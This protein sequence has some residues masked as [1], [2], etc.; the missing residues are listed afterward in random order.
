MALDPIPALPDQ[1]RRTRYTISPA[2]ADPVQVGFDIYGSGADPT[3]WIE[4]YVDGEPFTNWTLSSPSGPLNIIARPIT[5]AIITPG[6]AWSGTID[7]VAAERPFRTT[8][9]QDGRPVDPRTFN[10]AI[11][12]L[13][14]RQREAHDRFERTVKMPFGEDGYVFPFSANRNNT[15]FGFDANGDPALLTAAQDITQA[16]RFDIAQSLTDEQKQQARENIGAHNRANI[17]DWG[18]SPG[19]GAAAN[20]AAVQAAVDYAIENGVAIYVPGGVYLLN[21]KI[22]A[23]APITIYGDGF[24]ISELRWTADATDSGIEVV[25]GTSAKCSEVY[26]LSLTTLKVAEGTALT[27][28]YSGNIDG[29]NIVPR[30]YNRA[31][32]ARC[33][34]GGA[35]HYVTDGWLNGIDFISCLSCTVESCRINGIYQGTYGTSPLAENGISF[36]GSGQPTSLVVSATWISA[37][38]K[39]LYT[40]DA[41]GVYV[42]NC[43]FV[44]V[45]KGCVVNNA[46]GE[47]LFN[48]NNSHVASFVTGIEVT[49]CIAVNINGS[50]IYGIAADGGIGVHVKSG[51]IGGIIANNNFNCTDTNVNSYTGIKAE[52][53]GS[54]AG[55]LQI[56]DNTFGFRATS[57]ALDWVGI[58]IGAASSNVDVGRNDFR[59]VGTRILDETTT[60]TYEEFYNY[61]GDLNNITASNRRALQTHVLNTGATNT[62][63][64]I[65]SVAG[66]VVQTLSLNSN[67]AVQLLW[68]ATQSRIYL[69]TRTSG[70]WGSWVFIGLTSDGLPSNAALKAIAEL[71]PAAD[72]LPYFTDGTTAALADFTAFARTLVATSTARAA[73]AALGVP[74]V[75]AQ[76][77]V[78]VSHTGDT[79]ETILATITVPANA[80]GPNG[81]VIVTYIGS[82]TNN[83][84]N[85][86]FRIR[87]GGI[88]GTV[89]DQV[90]L[91]TS[92]S[93]RVQ[94]EIINRNSAM[95]QVGMVATIGGFGSSGTAI[96]TG[97]VDTTDAVDIVITG[98]LA[99]GTDTIALEAYRVEVV[100][101][102]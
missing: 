35:T 65:S 50:D 63:S 17:A 77:G 68:D 86:I 14:A 15:V 54:P 102:A 12:Q 28:D 13:T 52:T 93:V 51:A 100:Y 24:N 16:V 3:A 2:S 29:G 83:G 4:V 75:L 74:F 46:S 81:R 88:G 1:E 10:F 7:I 58:H 6:K 64:G 80:M 40:E 91:T 34:I 98:Q 61:T 38:K 25:A 84:N 39:G 70:S 73:A 56:H 82:V 22:T 5:D 55:R 45:D 69:R 18:A 87:F 43:E 90:T 96:T 9:L 21:D 11:T 85:K 36:G 95:S 19:A 53:G 66:C 89:F 27:F 26:D 42:T 41:E 44:S 60:T 71:T 92:P 97:S 31:K 8:Q 67:T 33:F 62:P 101:G 30:A 57:P 94:K 32:V 99:N 20:T 59:V 78:Q 48:F 23:D 37:W 49:N 72:K 79:N 76:S 47:P